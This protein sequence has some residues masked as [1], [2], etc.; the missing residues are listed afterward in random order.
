MGRTKYFAIADFFFFLMQAIFNV[1]IKFVTTSLLVSFGSL[2]MRNAGSLTRDQT[3]TPCI[4][5]ESQQL[6]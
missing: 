4:E 3:R 6:D 1:F 5:R 2:A